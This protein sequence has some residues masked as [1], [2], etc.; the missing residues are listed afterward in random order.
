MRP[1][2]VLH[3]QYI[4]LLPNTTVT[5]SI[6]MGK[7]KDHSEIPFKNFEGHRSGILLNLHLWDD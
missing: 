6:N 3:K 2:W 7:I 5:A 4:N 1:E